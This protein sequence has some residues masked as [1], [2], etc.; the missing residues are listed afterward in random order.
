M[1]L[2]KCSLNPCFDDST[3]HKRKVRHFFQN[4]SGSFPQDRIIPKDCIRRKFYQAGYHNIMCCDD[5]TETVN[6]ENQNETSNFSTMM[7]PITG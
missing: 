7:P 4:Q 3:G 2:P 5:E 6:E 1:F